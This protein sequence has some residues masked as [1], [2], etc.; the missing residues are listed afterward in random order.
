MNAFIFSLKFTLNGFEKEREREKERVSERERERKERKDVSS[1]C[2]K[3]K[4][5]VNPL[6]GPIEMDDRSNKVKV[7]T[8]LKSTSMDAGMILFFFTFIHDQ[9]V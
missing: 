4:A 3:N 5:K 1:S 8:R 7:S 6:E 9:V 2:N